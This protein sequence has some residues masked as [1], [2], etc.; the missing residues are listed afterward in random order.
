[1]HLLYRFC[2]AD[3]RPLPGVQFAAFDPGQPRRLAVLRGNALRLWDLTTDQEVCS[4]PHP[5]RNVW[6]LLFSPNGKELA[7]FGYEEKARCTVKRWDESTGRELPT[8][9]GQSNLTGALWSVAYSPDGKR[10]AT[11]EETRLRVWEG[12]TGRELLPVP[13]KFP[14]SFAG[15]AFS[16]DGKR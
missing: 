16:R 6:N 11:H 5:P 12:A 7:C 15:V 8:W 2:S 4:F 13:G 9:P 10:L 1:W 3:L 14:S